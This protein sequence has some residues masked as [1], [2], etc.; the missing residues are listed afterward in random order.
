[1]RGLKWAV[2]ALAVFNAGWMVFDGT[3]AL[4]VGDYETFDGG[5]GPWAQ[6][7][8]ALGIEPRSTLMKSIFVVWG[9][10]WLCVIAAFVRGVPRA[11]TGMLVAAIASLWYLP[12]GTLL[13]VLQI[14]L[15]SL[16]A[17]RERAVGRRLPA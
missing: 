4:V 5:L 8:E 11:R 12:M 3:R 1:V 7:V 13:S 17:R 6:I 14:V 15:L 9:A 10:V 16:L 2:V